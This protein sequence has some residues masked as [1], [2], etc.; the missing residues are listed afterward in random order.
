GRAAIHTDKG[1]ALARLMG[2]R[3]E[4]IMFVV[5]Q[6][7][8]LVDLGRWDAVIAVVA[9]YLDSTDVHITDSVLGAELLFGAWIHVWRGQ[10]P[11][12]RQLVER[13]ADLSTQG[14]G[15]Y[16]L[17][18]DAARAAVLRA[19]GRDREALEILADP[20]GREDLRSV[21]S[22]ASRWAFTESVESAFAVGDLQA[23][24]R[25]LASAAAR[26]SVT[27]TQIM[28]VH[29]IRFHARL[30]A[31]EGRYAE[32]QRTL[33]A[34]IAMFQQRQM[35][36]WVAVTRLEL[37]EWMVQRGR[38]DEAEGLLSDARGSF[39]E[40]A[41]SPWIERVDATAADAGATSEARSA[42]PA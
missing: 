8:V 23:V 21:D 2:Q 36:F 33:L 11:E 29:A 28:Q 38:R 4:E 35:P 31:L 14:G 12:A 7:P 9:D 13:L 42:L 18:H 25:Q 15:E 27:G 6:L 17:V 30:D 20:A 5:G 16:L 37:G 1:I 26:R 19:Q 40:L 3:R 39:V 10:I 22:D 34:A 32:V 41:A 24:R